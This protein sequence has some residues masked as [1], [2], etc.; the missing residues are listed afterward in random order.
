[1]SARMLKKC[2][3]LGTFLNCCFVIDFFIWKAGKNRKKAH[4]GYVIYEIG[5]NYKKDG[6][7]N[8][9]N[10]VRYSAFT[11]CFISFGFGQEF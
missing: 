10:R 11:Q 3:V 8:V 6:G 1:M 2:L 5:K 7:K 4:F 9:K